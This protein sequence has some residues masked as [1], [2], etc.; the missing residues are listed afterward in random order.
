MNIRRL[1]AVVAAG[2]A[3]TLGG[4]VATSAV[5]HADEDKQIFYTSM[6]NGVKGTAF[7]AFDFYRNDNYDQ[8]AI[9]SVSQSSFDDWCSYAQ[10]V[11]YSST[12]KLVR[13]EQPVKSCGP[14]VGAYTTTALVPVTKN[15]QF[16]V[17]SVWDDKGP[18]ITVR[19]DL[20]DP[21]NEIGT[22]G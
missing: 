19:R 2:V 16:V 4:L 14:Y 6:G 10:L 8:Y 21:D 15:A 13:T 7:A 20:W 12:N 18:K 3:M 9:V 5:A 1:C 22:R 11:W 17:L